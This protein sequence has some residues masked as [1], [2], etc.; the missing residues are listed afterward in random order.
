MPHPNDYER[1][2]GWILITLHGSMAL[3]SFLILYALFLLRASFAD[4]SIAFYMAVAAALASILF[5]AKASGVH[6]RIVKEGLPLPRLALKP[7]LFM[8]IL[9]LLAGRL[10]GG[11]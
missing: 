9:L 1:L 4:Q 7:F 8:A 2:R 3:L 6:F 5:N 11:L 10:F